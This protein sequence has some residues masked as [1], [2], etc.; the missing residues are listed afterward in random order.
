MKD[1]FL[2]QQL[3]LSPSMMPLNS[4][5]GLSTVDSN[6]G[7]NTMFQE[8]L[9]RNGKAKMYVSNHA[10]IIGGRERG[11]IRLKDSTCNT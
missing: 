6:H 1:C 7:V 3:L 8:I 10:T 5:R 2:I 9:E 4:A 11:S